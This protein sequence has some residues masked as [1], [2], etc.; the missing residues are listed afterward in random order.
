M[1]ECLVRIGHAM[2]VVLLLHRV[3]AIVGRVEQLSGET[4][5][6]RFLAAPARIRNYPTNSE[7]ATSLL[8]NFDRNL[9]GGSSYAP[10]LHFHG[11]THVLDGFLKNFERLFTGL[12]ANLSQ[13][14]VK[15][16]L[17]L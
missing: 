16:L 9:I 10:R 6:H 7:C 13:S 4:I 15:S 14:V 3:A 8:M 5:G 12:F 2:R 1:R 11:G 17:G